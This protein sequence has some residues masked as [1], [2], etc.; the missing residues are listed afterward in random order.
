VLPQTPA[1]IKALGMERANHPD[2]IVAYAMNDQP[3]PMLNGFPIVCGAG[4]YATIGV[5]A[6]NDVNVLAEPF[7]ASGWT[8]RIAFPPKTRTHRETPD[9]L[10]TDTVAD[11]RDDDALR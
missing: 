5:K 7:K 9:K 3:M 6:L 1:F 10:A 4:W 8:R 11:Q 2:T